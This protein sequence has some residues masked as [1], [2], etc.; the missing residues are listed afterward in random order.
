MSRTPDIVADAAYLVFSK[1]AR[2]FTGH[3]LVDDSFLYA[4]GGL[5]DF[6]PYG[7][8]RSRASA[9]RRPRQD[10]VFRSVVSQIWAKITSPIGRGRLDARSTTAG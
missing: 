9:R 10:I 8:I 1:P 7:P 2:G 3:F 6:S 4:E 5:R